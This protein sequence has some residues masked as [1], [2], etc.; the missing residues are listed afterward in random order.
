MENI[1]YLHCLSKFPS[2]FSCL[3][4]NIT[5]NVKYRF[6]IFMPERMPN[7]LFTRFNLYG[8]T[9]KATIDP[10]KKGEN[11]PTSEQ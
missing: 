4:R 11:L 2:Q 9:T 6:V 10:I 8:Y 5:M 3:K 7:K 1:S